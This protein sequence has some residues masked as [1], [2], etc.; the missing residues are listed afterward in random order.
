MSSCVLHC[1]RRTTPL[2]E[3]IS[4]DVYTLLNAVDT[5]QIICSNRRQQILPPISN[6]YYKVQVPCSCLMETTS[7]QPPVNLIELGVSCTSGAEAVVFQKYAN[8]IISTDGAFGNLSAN[9]HNFTVPE[10]AKFKI[11]TPPVPRSGNFWE[12]L[13]LSGTS[14]TELRMRI[15]T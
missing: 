7:Q 15:S 4:D 6:G 3:Q 10:A 11:L 1:D 13:P 14:Y 5:V 12:D 8:E 9:T 2:V